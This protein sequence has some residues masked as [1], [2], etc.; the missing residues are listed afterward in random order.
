MVG[1]DLGMQKIAK[2]GNQI[3]FQ[4]K[5]LFGEGSGKDVWSL[6]KE[7]SSIKY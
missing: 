1:S 3:G 5:E 7:K 6:E 2:P 4:G